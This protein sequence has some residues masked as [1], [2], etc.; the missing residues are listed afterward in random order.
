ME[1]NKGDRVVVTSTIEGY[2]FL[3]VGDTAVLSYTDEGGYW[4]AEFDERSWGEH[5]I[6]EEDDRL[7]CL[8]PGIAE[9]KLIEKEEK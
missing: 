9:F 4:W 5:I 8:Q 2:R 6:G 1:F 3:S 7:F